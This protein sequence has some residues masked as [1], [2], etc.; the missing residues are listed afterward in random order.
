MIQITL[1]D[2]GVH[3]E[4]TRLLRR[5]QD[6]T[7]ALDAIG[8]R[9]VDFTKDRFEVSQDP[10][11]TPWEPNKDSTLRA[12]LHSNTQNFTRRGTVSARGAE[13]ADRQEAADRRRPALD[14]VSP[15]RPRPRR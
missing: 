14:P 11:G 9:I 10:Y 12:M 5:F 15:Q 6:P 13:L 1:T 4:L 2:T 3:A 7:P 8:V